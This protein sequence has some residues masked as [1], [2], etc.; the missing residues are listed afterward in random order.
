MS[1]SKRADDRRDRYGFDEARNPLV[2]AVGK[3]VPQ[4]VVRRA[5]SI[6]VETDR[7]TYAPGDPVELTVTIAN[8]LPL[9]VVAETETRRLW[10][11]TVDGE[12]EASDERVY[13]GDAP[14]TLAFRPKE[15]KVIALAWDGRFKRVGEE[16]APT[17]WVEADPGVHEVGAFLALP[18][19]RLDDAVE[20]RMER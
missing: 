15:R 6:R 19:R 10:G 17:R 13:V 14:G 1:S 2:E 3:F 12:L 16:G 7:E 20:I 5:L 4:S 8:T 9:P 18:G 11:W